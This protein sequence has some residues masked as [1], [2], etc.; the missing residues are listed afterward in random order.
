MLEPIAGQLS[1]FESKY[2]LA[3]TLQLLT[4]CLFVFDV[5]MAVYI[6]FSLTFHL[7][8]K[9][10]GTVLMQTKTSKDESA[11]KCRPCYVLGS[12]ETD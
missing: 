12:T 8:W 1:Y 3:F 10:D 7:P 2:I 9:L 5:Q 11:R 6:V 4:G